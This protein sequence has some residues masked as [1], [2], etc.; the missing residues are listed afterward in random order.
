MYALAI[1]SVRWRPVYVWVVH[2]ECSKCF[3]CQIRFRGA[4]VKY[5]VNVTALD[6][7]KSVA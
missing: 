5:E 1:D 2:T 7:A 3:S 4:S 6:L